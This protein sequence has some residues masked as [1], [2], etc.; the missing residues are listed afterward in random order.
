MFID[1]TASV[2]LLDQLKQGEIEKDYLEPWIAAGEVEG[3]K[4]G[5][6]FYLDLPVPTANI[7]MFTSGWGDGFQASYFRYD[8]NGEVVA[9]LTE[10]Q[11][12]DWSLDK[13]PVG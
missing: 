7:I 12:M 11:V 2:A 1:K 9:L 4:L 6:L 13:R 10:F 8:V 5:M 3:K